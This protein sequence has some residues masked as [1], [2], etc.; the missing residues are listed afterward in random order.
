V[1]HD[2]VDDS[3]QRSSTETDGAALVCREK[4]AT[5]RRV[6][7]AASRRAK[8]TR[9]TTPQEL[10]ATRAP[11]G[12]ELAS[13]WH[14]W[15]E[16]V[17]P[18]QDLTALLGQVL[19]AAVRLGEDGELYL[20]EPT[21]VALVA[22]VG[23]RVVCGATLRWEVLGIH[24]PIAIESIAVVVS[25]E[26]EE[27]SDGRRL[28]FKIQIEHA[29]VA[30]L[31]RLLGDG[32]TDLVNRELAAKHV[33]LSWNHT[34]TL[35]HAFELPPSLLSHDQ[36]ALSVVDARVKATGDALGLAIRFGAT[37]RRRSPKVDTSSL[38]P[39]GRSATSVP[40]TQR[41]PS[42][43]FRVWSHPWGLGVATLVALCGAY[44]L[45]R[46]H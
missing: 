22:D 9:C 27:R 5:A 2:V 41:A 31:P 42:R 17:V 11:R 18:Q 26:I 19:P 39:E 16:A 45:G 3:P 35:S 28:V 14:M 10:I 25:P 12:L 37:A 36:L 32:V 40:V 44:A 6:E 38:P 43:L 13:A 46:S 30:G 7:A 29:D 1:A 23:L 34:A 4:V 21:G 8:A 15:V 24:V 20:G 33:E